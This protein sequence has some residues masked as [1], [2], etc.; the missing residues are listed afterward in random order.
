[1]KKRLM[2]L[3]ICMIIITN[4][5]SVFSEH[6]LRTDEDFFKR[7]IESINEDGLSLLQMKMNVFEHLHEGFFELSETV[8]YYY[9]KE[10]DWKKVKD[11]I[12]NKLQ[13]FASIDPEKENRIINLIKAEEIQNSF[14]NLKKLPEEEQDLFRQWDSIM[15]Q[16]IAIEMLCESSD[17]NDLIQQACA[18]L[19]EGL[20]DPRTYY[21]P[22]EEWEF[23]YGNSPSTGGIGLDISMDYESGQ[24]IVARA[25]NGGPAQKAGVHRGDMLL[26]VDNLSIIPET[27][28]KAV[29]MMRGEP[30]T[31]LVITVS[32]N[33]EE[34][35]FEL[36]RENIEKHS[37]EFNLLDNKIGLIKVYDLGGNADKL[38]RDAF[39]AL[40]SNGVKALVIDLRDSTGGW[41]DAGVN[42]AD[43]FMESGD[44]CYL[45]YRGNEEDHAYKT[46][47]GSIDIPM[48][49]LINENTA[50]A[51][52][53]LAAAL[54][55]RAE[56][57]LIGVNTKGYN[58]VQAVMPLFGDESGYQITIA[59]VFTPDGKSFAGKGISPDVVVPL[60]EG[61]VGEYA[62]ADLKHDY[63]LKKAVDI[64]SE[65]MDSK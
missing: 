12:S 6:S 32:R 59:E 21:L 20:E 62:F 3:I 13:A 29:S 38:F 37:V 35:Q 30:G 5:T 52:E 2:I 19:L 44:F 17:L 43:L 48:T 49:V 27:L 51:S 39:A 22:P 18:G 14:G 42:I 11:Y 36:K 60:Q 57:K 63:Q 24:C 10:P 23:L 46:T 50:S 61:D 54:Q 25:I 31:D 65:I 26:K 58:T 15:N 7:A 34:L 40:L 33:G 56:A 45:V 64:I 53:M 55:E 8:K 28:N 41:I 1:M 16:M 9:Y 4:C 47:N